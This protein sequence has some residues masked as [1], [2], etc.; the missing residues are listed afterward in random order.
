L[1]QEKGIW[2]AE[3]FSRQLNVIRSISGAPIISNKNHYTRFEGWGELYEWCEQ[4]G[5]EADQ[6]R[7]PSKKGNVGFPFGTSHPYYPIAR[8]DDRNRLYRVLE[9]GFLTQDLEH[10]TLSDASVIAPFLEKV[11][12]VRGVAHFL[13]HQQ[14]IHHLGNVRHAFSLAVETAKR[15]G[16]AFWTS[17]EITRWEQARRTAVLRVSA[18]GTLI[19]EN[20]PQ[21]AVVRQPLAAEADPSA[22][23]T[24]IRF[25]RPCAEAASMMK[26]AAE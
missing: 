15:L 8:S 7:G 25:G 12:E 20:L 22:S 13:F 21:G 24:D 5:I 26:T 4:N 23:Q 3:E 14:H 6:T 16:Y 2:S 18:D 11:A 9:I 10:P 1:E 17:E 19:T